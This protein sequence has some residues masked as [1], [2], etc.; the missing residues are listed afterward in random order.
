[1][2]IKV[3]TKQSNEHKKVNVYSDQAE[4]PLASFHLKFNF[5]PGTLTK[6]H[7]LHVLKCKVASH[8]NEMKTSLVE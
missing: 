3:Q 8:V 4:K 2:L 1:M 5:I 6:A 7:N